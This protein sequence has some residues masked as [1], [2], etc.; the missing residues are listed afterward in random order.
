MYNDHGKLMYSAHDKNILA[1]LKIENDFDLLDLLAQAKA[2][3]GHSIFAIAYALCAMQ[4]PHNNPSKAGSELVAIFGKP[5]ELTA[6]IICAFIDTKLEPI[7]QEYLKILQKYPENA[8]ANYML[9]LH[10]DNEREIKK[11]KFHLNRSLRIK[12]FPASIIAYFDDNKSNLSAMEKKKLGLE[13]LRLVYDKHHENSANPKYLRKYVKITLYELIHGFY[14]T[15]Q[16]WDSL[17]SE[18]SLEFC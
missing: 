2:E 12:K 4:P 13:L 7:Q 15:S 1:A 3:A 5:A 8:T 16:N 6:A 17:V 9:S 14:M 18:L 11:H 10:Y